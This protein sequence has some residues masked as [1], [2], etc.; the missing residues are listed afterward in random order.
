[1][2]RLH[3]IASFNFSKQKLKARTAPA[4]SSSMLDKNPGTPQP[5][6]RALSGANLSTVAVRHS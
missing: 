6:E 5:C 3:H 4:R 1:M 2:G